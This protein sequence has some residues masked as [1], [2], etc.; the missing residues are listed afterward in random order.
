MDMSNPSVGAD[1]NVYIGTL[2]D[3]LYSISSSGALTW[4]FATAAGIQSSPAVGPDGTVYL[5]GATN[6]SML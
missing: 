1:G 2:D 6:T 3:N 4:K 5:L